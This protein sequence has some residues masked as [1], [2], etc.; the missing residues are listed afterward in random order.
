MIAAEASADKVPYEFRPAKQV[1]RRMLLELFQRLMEA[2]FRISGYQYTGMGS[3]YF[4][5]FIMFH[6]YLGIKKMVSVECVE[7]IEKRVHFNRPYGKTV[8]DIV[9][10]DIAD[11]IPSL[12][13]DRKHIL[14]LDFNFVVTKGAIDAIV[15][16][17]AQLSAGSILLVTVDA[18]PPGPPNWG[19][20]KWCQYFKSEAGDFLGN[21]SLNKHFAR[22]N[23]DEVNA[24]I[25]EKA[26]RLGLAGRDDVI[27]S[28][29]VNFVYA[30]G[31]R[32]LSV[33]GMIAS[34][35]DRQK[36]LQL[37]RIK[38]PFVRDSITGNPYPIKVPLL[39]RKERLHL[40]AAMPCRK[41]WRPNEFEMTPDD[42]KIYS[43][44]YPYFPV[45]T[46]GL[47]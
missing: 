43:E 13:R 5:D 2:G 22:S 18:E 27:F 10:G 32:M 39:T 26:I 6:R 14:W 9:M 30:D 34:E 35:D 15:L 24:S 42:I 36:L 7:A 17:A 1:E 46:E 47:L 16:A 3:F 21:K 37:D 23:L 33:G 25:V 44:I 31:H 40:D 20:K 11:F 12:S 28:P 19:P 38:M 4:V 29:L 45:Y 8:L 41:S